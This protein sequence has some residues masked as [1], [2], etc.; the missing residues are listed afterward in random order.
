MHANA[1]VFEDVADKA[2]SEAISLEAIKIEPHEIGNTRTKRNSR[3]QWNGARE[4][5]L[6]CLNARS[7]VGSACE[8]FVRCF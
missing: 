4:R 3:R 1:V 8:T 7:L 2:I 6:F 5:V